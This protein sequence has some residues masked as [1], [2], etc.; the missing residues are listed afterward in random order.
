MRSTSLGLLFC[1][2]L[3]GILS[4]ACSAESAATETSD[5]GV[6]TAVPTPT[7]RGPA[8]GDSPY[9]WAATTY[10]EYQA[11]QAAPPFLY[12]SPENADPIAARLQLWADAI[13]ARVRAETLRATG[14]PLL[15]PRPIVKIVGASVPNAWVSSA[16][17]C[18]GPAD[19]VGPQR[20]DQTARMATLR[21]N[22]VMVP[23]QVFGERGD[24]AP[25][26]SDWGTN[27]A[28]YVAWQ[29]GLGAK[30]TLQKTGSRLVVQGEGC[31]SIDS[32]THV[33]NLAVVA[34]SPF[35]HVTSAMIEAAPDEI[36][37]ASVLAHELGHYF[38]AHVVADAMENKFNYWFK[39]TSP[40]TPGRPTKI[41]ESASLEAGIA[42]LT[43][44]VAHPIAGQVFSHRMQSMLLSYLPWMLTEGS[45]APAAAAAQAIVVKS[46]FLGAT[47]LFLP[48]QQK[49]YL[50]YE[51]ALVTCAPNSHLGAPHEPTLAGLR[52]GVPQELNG[53]NLDGAQTLESVLRAINAFAQP[54]DAEEDALRTR[55]DH[56]HLGRFTG[57]E[58][59]DDF[60][61][62][63]SVATG[64]TPDRRFQSELGLERKMYEAKPE[65]FKPNNGLTFD[66]CESLAKA[67]FVT[68]GQTE[69][70]SLG[71]NLTEPHHSTCFRL[72]NLV[73]R[74][75][76][77]QYVAPTTMAVVPSTDAEW[78]ALQA[79]ARDLTQKAHDIEV[80]PRPMTPGGGSSGG[81][82]ILD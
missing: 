24:C 34:T 59:A 28:D 42:R 43:N 14:R 69:F 76:A 82:I 12:L 25:A 3:V 7:D 16:S 74:Q 72:F 51:A 64:I 81:V 73:A 52:T 79:H 77:Q 61:L 11:S 41:A 63:W 56:D 21:G 30:C 31:V 45:C 70:V 50:A 75:Q 8:A 49:A 71:F 60:G 47:D 37:A 55:I 33:E 1:A 62:R 36:A 46:S 53:V 40:L 29:S 57:E 54:I 66:A 58:S 23:L 17:V 18:L 2:T 5:Q 80:L 39:P 67:K 13:D 44:L 38:E 65:Q 20:P 10:E 35:V 22:T 78:A 19:L 32:P 4:N 6:G 15:A 9:Y 27:T 68:G 48:E 26:P